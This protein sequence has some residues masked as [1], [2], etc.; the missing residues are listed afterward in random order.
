[1]AGLLLSRLKSG[2][3]LD[4]RTD[5]LERA[6][7]MRAVLEGMGFENLAGRGRFSERAEGELPSTREKRYLASGLPV[8]RLRLRRPENEVRGSGAT[9]QGALHGA[10]GREE[11][12]PPC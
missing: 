2:G 5:V 7:E 11:Q 1:M 8:Y 6:L 12:E 10:G 9:A 3:V 4:L